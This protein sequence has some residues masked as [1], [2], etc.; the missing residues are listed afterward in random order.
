MKKNKFLREIKNNFYDEK[1]AVG[2]RQKVNELY[3]R[4][5]L[6]KRKIVRKLGMSMKFVIRWTRFRK[7]DFTCDRRGW[8]KGKLRKLT[9]TTKARIKA[10]HADLASDK[11]N[12]FCGA[13]FFSF[14]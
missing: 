2:L 9:M 7:M 13:L 1:K 11:K 4:F 12:Y 5:N 6:S 3:F 8:E 10:L 14:I